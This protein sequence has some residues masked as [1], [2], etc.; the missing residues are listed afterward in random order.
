MT[1]SKRVNP[2]GI[3]KALA[4]V[5]V[6]RETLQRVKLRVATVLPP[7]LLETPLSD[8]L[9]HAYMLG[10][11][12]SV[13]Q[14]APDEAPHRYKPHPRHPQFCA[15]CGYAEHERIKHAASSEKDHAA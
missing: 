9:A 15:V 6:T 8:L 11:R 2:R 4:G 14:L 5:P 10:V 12:D 7:N 3:P 13:Q 1:L